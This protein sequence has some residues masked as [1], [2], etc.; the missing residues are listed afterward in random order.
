MK[1]CRDILTLNRN[2]K[3]TTIREFKHD[4]CDKGQTAKIYLLFLSSNPQVNQT[5]IEKCLPLFTANTTI[6]SLRY[7]QLKTDCKTFVFAISRL[8]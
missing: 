8:T 1:G 5:K 4:V 2:K 3:N 6:S 7:I